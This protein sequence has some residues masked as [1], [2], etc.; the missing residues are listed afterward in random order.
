MKGILQ[1]MIWPLLVTLFHLNTFAGTSPMDPLPTEETEAVSNYSAKGDIITKSYDLKD[2]TSVEVSS[3]LKVT[4]TSGKDFKVKITGDENIF[5]FI[6]IKVSGETLKAKIDWRLMKSFSSKE[7]SNLHL[8]IK[9]PE[10]KAIDISGAVEAKIKGFEGDKLEATLS[11]ASKVTMD[12]EMKEL[13]IDVSGA[14][15]LLLVGKADVLKMDGSGASSVDAFTLEAKQ[16]NIISSGASSAKVNVSETLNVNGSGASS[17]YYMGDAEVN[18]DISG[19]SSVK[20]K[21]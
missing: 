17:I 15:K 10:L 5:D 14:A 21:K 20:K 13:N 11:G 4:I 3:A 12:I 7:K 19:A 18:S 6:S 9:M 16:I 1:S 8:E 2:F